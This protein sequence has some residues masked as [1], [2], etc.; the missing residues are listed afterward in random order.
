MRVQVAIAAG[1]AL[2]WAAPALAQ[3]PDPVPRAE[4]AEPWRVPAGQ[5][6]TTPAGNKARVT[7]D[8]TATEPSPAEQ[9]E[10]RALAAAVFA[11]PAA[12]QR[13]VDKVAPDAAPDW[14]AVQPREE[15]TDKVAPGGRG[16]KV[17]APF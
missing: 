2:V 7:S 12:A 17:T 13:A 1:F 5:P 8:V 6:Y 9:K 11:K 3:P 4:R 16:V 14:A 10:A 15:W